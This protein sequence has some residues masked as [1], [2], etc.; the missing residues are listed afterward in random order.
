M[1]TENKGPVV[2]VHGAWHGGWCWHEVVD[3]LERLGRKV[4][5]PTLSGMAH[6]RAG[7]NKDISAD[8]H[9]DD[10]ATLV[11]ALELADVTLV[12][13]SYAGLLGPALLHRLQ[14]RLTEIAWIEAV[15]PSPGMPML[16]LTTPKAAA[17]Y[18]QIAASEGEGWWMPPPSATQFQLPTSEMEKYVDH[19]LTPQPFRTFSEPVS[20][21][22]ADVKAFPGR[23]LIAS[24]RKPQPYLRYAAIATASGWPV[25]DAPGGHLMMLTNSDAVVNFLN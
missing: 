1:S 7:L 2:L 15:I 13:H 25:R 16:E 14:G 20:L 22:Q 12:L 19:R 4:Y 3:K 24:D 21:P 9:V 5:A 18:I 11:E 17:R 10:I 6:R 23:Y 8:T